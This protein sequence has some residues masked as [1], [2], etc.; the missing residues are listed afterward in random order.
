MLGFNHVELEYEIYPGELGS[1]I[2]VRWGGF[3][4]GVTSDYRE[5]IMLYEWHRAIR[6]R[7]QQ[8]S[9]IFTMAA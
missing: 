9:P 7:W 5:A 1:A 6:E 8:E 4:V 2:F 3:L